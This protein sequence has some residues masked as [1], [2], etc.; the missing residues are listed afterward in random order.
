MVIWAKWNAASISGSPEGLNGQEPGAVKVD[1]HSRLHVCR[2]RFLA[3][4]A[5]EMVFFAHSPKASHRA[6]VKYFRI[7][8]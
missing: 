6:L 7:E 1:E 2:Y 5:T 3:R 4:N 8:V